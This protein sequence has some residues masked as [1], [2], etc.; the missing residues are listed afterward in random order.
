MKEKVIKFFA[1]NPRVKA[2]ALLAI[3]ALVLFAIFG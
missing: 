1:E 3:S 2:I